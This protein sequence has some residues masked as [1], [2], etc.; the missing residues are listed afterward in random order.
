M[1]MLE[2]WVD[3]IC[4]KQTYIKNIR[5]IV[6]LALLFAVL[7]AWLLW[8]YYPVSQERIQK[9]NLTLITKTRYILSVDS[10]DILSF[11]DTRGDT[12]LTGITAK[13]VTTDSCYAQWVRR[14]QLL[15][16][17]NGTLTTDITD[18]ASICRKTSKQ[19]ATLLNKEAEHLTDELKVAEEQ[20]KDIDYFLKTHTVIDN[21]FDIVARYGEDLVKSTDSIV[22]ASKLIAKAQKGKRFSI[23]MEKRYFLHGADGT[24]ECMPITTKDSMLL[25]KVSD[26]GMGIR[27]SRVSVNDAK[28]QLKTRKA[29]VPVITLAKIDS[30]G[31]YTGARDSVNEPHGYGRFLSIDGDFYEGEW[32]HGQR[33]GVGFSMVPGKRLRLGEW[34][35]DKF[36]GERIAYTPERIYGIDISRYQHEKGRKRFGINWK[37]LRITSLGHLSKK[38]IHGKVDYPVRFIFIKAT[39]GTT[40]KNKYFAN[41]YANARKYGYKTGAYHFFSIKTPGRN[42]AINFLKN[43]KYNHGDLPPVLD[44]E[45]SDA[46]IRKAGGIHALF[47]NVRSWLNAVEKQRGVRPILYISQRF[48]N[49]YLPSAPDLQ[50]N[51]DVW[52][53]RYGEYKPDVNLVYWQLSPDGR[54]RGIQ[55]EVDI[56]VYNGFNF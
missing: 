5:I 20:R 48:V 9:S 47:N 54:V 53:A 28:A 32:T 46:E 17:S 15:P 1:T 37:D 43:S 56:N 26:E 7:M 3:M 50:K 19:I 41:D 25:L 34:K 49:K 21:G 24:K 18:T 33:S 23:R 27:K 10:T 12:L 29:K 4:K 14:F 52:I 55:T 2:A 11:T 22:N 44:L 42:Q 40:I 35:E 51:Y 8:Y 30:L 31:A 38:T 36:L 39:E 6:P 13:G 16:F 45:P